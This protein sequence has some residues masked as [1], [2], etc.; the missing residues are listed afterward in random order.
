LPVTA[1]DSIK[2]FRAEQAVATQPDS[3]GTSA[4]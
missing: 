1:P 4:P 2:A 3:S